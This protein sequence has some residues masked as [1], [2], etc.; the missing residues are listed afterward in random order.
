MSVI[1]TKLGDAA[2]RFQ[3]EL[4]KYYKVVKTERSTFRSGEVTK[5][6]IIVTIMDIDRKVNKYTVAIDPET[7]K[8]S[9]LGSHIGALGN[10]D[11][12]WVNQYLVYTK[13]GTSGNEIVS[14][15]ERPD[16]TKPFQEAAA[17]EGTQ[18]F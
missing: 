8:G 1:P 9:R 15:K 4:N 11:A 16:I 17:I 10:D 5:P 2:P 3:P 12:K 7:T 18:E 14:Y 6:S 13:W